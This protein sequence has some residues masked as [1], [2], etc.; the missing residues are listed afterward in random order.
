M[1]L[2]TV[3]LCAA[4][5]MAASLFPRDVSASRAAVSGIQITRLTATPRVVGLSHLITFTVAVRGIRLSYGDMG[6]PPVVGEGHLQYYL[7]RIPRDAWVRP[8]VHRTFLAA[9]GTPITV[10]RFSHTA[11]RVDPGKHVILVALAKNNYVLYHSPIAHVAIRV[12]P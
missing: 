11:V 7:D 4:A 12:K 8:D 6:K 5:L 9:V 2:V 1:S 10:F 3:A